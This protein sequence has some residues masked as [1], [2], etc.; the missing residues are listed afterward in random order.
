MIPGNAVVMSPDLP[1]RA[2]QRFG[3]VFLNKFE[4]SVCSSSSLRA[5]TLIDSP[6]V[7]SGK[8]QT[9]GRQY[10]FAGVV[11][12]FAT[13]AD[14]ILLL[15]DAHKLDIGDEFKEVVQSLKGK[16]TFRL[17]LKY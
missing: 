7:L 6:G 11:N 3:N 12:W 4:A 10:D 14:R 9:K 1:F 13:R 2:L 8:K 17:L 5:F 15:F 16:K